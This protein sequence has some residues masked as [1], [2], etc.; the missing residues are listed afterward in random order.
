MCIKCKI[1]AY[2]IQLWPILLPNRSRA[3]TEKLPFYCFLLRGIKW[4]LYVLSVHKLAVK[5]T[6]FCLQ[7]Q[8]LDYR[9]KIEAKQHK[10]VER[11]LL[12]GIRLFTQ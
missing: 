4:L 11:M 1:S 7:L 10:A 3:D 9:K 5:M 8:L 12:A 6:M 2:N